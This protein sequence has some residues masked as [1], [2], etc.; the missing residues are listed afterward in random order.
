MRLRNGAQVLRPCLEQRSLR[1]QSVKEAELAQLEP[2]AGG[3][4]G[5]LR[6]RQQVLAQGLGL[7]PIRAQQ[8]PRL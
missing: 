7:K 4:I 6:A 5:R 3:V 1:V 8:F 2:F